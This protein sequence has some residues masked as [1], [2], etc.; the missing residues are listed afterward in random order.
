MFIYP[1]PARQV[2]VKPNMPLEN[3]QIVAAGDIKPI[4]A[5]DPC[6]AGGHSALRWPANL[7]VDIVMRLALYLK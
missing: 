6:A 7:I 1:S 2:A 4:A 3:F 5:V